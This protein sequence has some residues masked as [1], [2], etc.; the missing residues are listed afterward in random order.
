[1][2][3]FE[4]DGSFRRQILTEKHRLLYMCIWRS[5]LIASLSISLLPV[6][7]EVTILCHSFPLPWHLVSRSI[8]QFKEYELWHLILWTNKSFL[9]LI[10][11]VRYFVLEWKCLIYYSCTE[12]LEFPLEKYCSLVHFLLLTAQYYKYNKSYRFFLSQF[13]K[14]KNINS[15]L[16]ENF[17]AKD[18]RWQKWLITSPDKK[19]HGRFEGQSQ[20]FVET[21]PQ[22]KFWILRKS[23]LIIVGTASTVIETLYSSYYRYLQTTSKRTTSVHE[24]LGTDHAQPTT[25][26]SLKLSE[27]NEEVDQWAPESKS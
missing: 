22:E 14:V 19:P 1:M 17:R 16:S 7:Y 10:C 18:I 3:L 12:L 5:N 21:Y 13:S 23:N 24:V 26:S 11:S 6:Y 8:G 15:D 25:P 20:V 2:M 4:W 27:C 9:L